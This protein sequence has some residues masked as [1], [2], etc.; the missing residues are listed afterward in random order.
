MA[1]YCNWSTETP[2]FQRCRQIAVEGTYRCEEHQIKRKTRK[3]HLSGSQRAAVR[4]AFGGVCAIPGCTQSAHEVDHIVE[5]NEFAPDEKWK[6][7]LPSNLQVLCF[8][9]HLMKTNEYRK[10][11]IDLG[12]PN[13]TSTSARNRKKK[14]VNKWR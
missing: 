1:R 10:S 6:A 13:D 4:Q 2:R 8:K 3:G 7:N 11:L 12:D 14:R 5:V 9:H